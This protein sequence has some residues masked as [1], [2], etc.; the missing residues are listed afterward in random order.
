MVPSVGLA[1]ELQH[2]VAQLETAGKISA[3]PIDLKVSF[4][5]TKGAS[6]KAGQFPVVRLK[7]G[8]DAYVTAIYFSDNGDATVL[9]PNRGISDCRFQ[10]DKDYTLFGRESSLKL[11]SDANQK[12]AKI[13]FYISSTPVQLAPLAIPEGQDF[14][15]IPVSTAKERSELCQ[16]IEAASSQGAG[17]NRKVLAL[18]AEGKDDA[19]GIMGLPTEAKSG[20]PQSVT[21]VQGL[22]GNILDS[23]K[24]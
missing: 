14:I 12:K 7:V 8:M 10:K 5:K 20:R 3:N 9:L 6:S 13:V 22:K 15:T 24:E 19:Y 16:K 17:F 11:A 18:K 1:S 21:G 4:D 2:P 23:P